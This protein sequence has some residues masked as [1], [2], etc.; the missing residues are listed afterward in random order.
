MAME[1]PKGYLWLRYVCSVTSDSATLCAIARQAPLSM[2][3][4]RQ[5]YWSGLPF[6]PPGN[7]HDPGIEPS[8]LASLAL[9][10][11]FFTTEPL[12]KPIKISK[13]RRGEIGGSLERKQGERE[14]L[15]AGKPTNWIGFLRN[16]RLKRAPSRKEAQLRAV[17]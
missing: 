10:G 7:L 8:S 9:A 5:E 13:K 17:V 3:F 12:G 2:G 15:K 4:F 6:P 14:K 11:R 16:W 1:R